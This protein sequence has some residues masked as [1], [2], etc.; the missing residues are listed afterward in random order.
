VSGC[1][2]T[3]AILR[4]DAKFSHNLASVVDRQGSGLHSA[5]HIDRGEGRAVFEKSVNVR[6]ISNEAVRRTDAECPHNL[7]RVVDPEGSGLH[8]AG[9]I[10]RGEG[11]AV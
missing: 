10:D 7:A 1:A 2:S 9:H 8:S 11:R 4:N 5:G 6:A 3:E